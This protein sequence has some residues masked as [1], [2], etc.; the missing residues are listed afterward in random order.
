MKIR[1]TK[2]L[3]YVL[4]T[5]ISDGFMS[6]TGLIG[7]TVKDYDYISY[8]VDCMNNSFPWLKELTNRKDLNLH[9]DGRY[10]YTINRKE[11]TYFI[12]QLYSYSTYTHSWK[13]PDCI[14]FS[15]NEKIIGNFLK[16]FFDGD[17]NV[18]VN[19]IKYNIYGT[20][21]VYSINKIGINQIGNLLSFL[22]IKHNLY[23]LNRKGKI[24]K[25]GGKT[26][27]I[28]SDIYAIGIHKLNSVKQFKTKIGFN[29]KR[30]QEKLLSIC[31]RE[32]KR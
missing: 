5:L 1:L 3:A 32:V 30:K 4:G 31:N 16:A 21:W 29:I 25:K 19:K 14:L 12:K 15:N 6:P 26:Y 7:L 27:I 10:R 28:K 23:K 22:K 8:F 11:I 13:V 20:V 17:G 2:E 9:S 24:L 18:R